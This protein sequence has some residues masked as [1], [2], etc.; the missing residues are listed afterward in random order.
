MCKEYPQSL[1]EWDDA[2]DVAG[3]SK[4]ESVEET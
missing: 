4:A 3:S 2:Y 1:A